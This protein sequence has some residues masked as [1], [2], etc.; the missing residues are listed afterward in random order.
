MNDRDLVIDKARSYIGLH[1]TGD[2][3]T[4]FGKEYGEDGV[5]WCDIFVWCIFNRV[6]LVGLLPG[7]FD[8]CG[9]S[10]EAWKEMG[11]FSEYPALGAQV[12]FGPG[13]GEHTGIVVD[14]GPTT[15][16]SVEGNWND[17]VSQVTRE[18][19]DAFVFGYGYPRFAEGIRS[20]DPNYQPQGGEAPIQPV[21]APAD[22]QP[23]VL[24]VGQLNHAA[25]WDPPAEQGHRSYCWPQ[26]LRLE[27]ALESEGLLAHAFVDGSYGSVTIDAYRRLQQNLGYAGQAAD[28]KPGMA[29][30]SWLGSRHGF[31]AEP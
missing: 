18:R 12:V 14:Y 4:E 9:R 26:V 22:G 7:K 28:G 15:V 6:G 27:Q 24:Y 10:T 8:N 19:R 31:R 20:A 16:T 1:E 25:S 13:G 30:L 17:Q 3:R 23:D 5:A 2:N 21:P 11:R 29:S